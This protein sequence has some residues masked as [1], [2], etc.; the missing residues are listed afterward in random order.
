MIYA[1]LE[2]EIRDA[3][4][5]DENLNENGSINWNFVDADAYAECRSFWKDDEDFYESFNEI[6]DMIIA[7]RKEEAA[8]ETQIDMEFDLLARY[9]NAVEQLEVLKTDFLGM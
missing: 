9:P 2:I 4:E 5:K 3:V 6:A 7:E 1:M 8:A